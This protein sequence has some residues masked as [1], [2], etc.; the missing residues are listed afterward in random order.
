MM[1]RLFGLFVFIVKLLL[2]F[3]VVLLV[4]LVE[5]EDVE[6][7]F[8]VDDD[9]DDDS[10]W[11]DGRKVVLT[12]DKVAHDNDDDVV[13]GMNADVKVDE[14]DSIHSAVSEG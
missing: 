12:G 13:D 9:D 14:E 1:I 8:V 10:E 11:R 6:W 2:L 3:D 7:R 5:V 4:L